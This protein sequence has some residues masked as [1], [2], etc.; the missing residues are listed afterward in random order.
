MSKVILQP[1]GGEN[2]TR[3]LQDTILNR[4]S[5]ETIGS[6]VTSEQRSALARKFPSGSA[7]VW[8]VVPGKGSNVTKWNRIE[9]HDT[10]LFTG[11]GRIFGRAEVVERFESKALAL[12]L[13]GTDE[14]GETWEYL[15]FLDSY[16][17]CDI[18]YER[19]NELVGYEPSFV[20]LGFN[21][22]TEEKSAEFL[23]AY[24]HS[25]LHPSEYIKALRAQQT[26]DREIL[27]SQRLEQQFLRQGLFGK[28]AI[29]TCCIC[30]EAYPV[31]FLVAAHVKPR[32]EC[33]PNELRD[34]KHIVAPMCRFGCDELYERGYIG[35]EGGSIVAVVSEPTSDMLEIYR[36][37]LVGRACTAWNEQSSRYFEWHLTRHRGT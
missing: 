21:V 2:A 27:A 7:L 19:F 24:N 16:E 29:G 18:P 5:L 31:G 25:N 4:V 6:H 30:G 11:H 36:E 20:P 1:A 14:D 10:A 9:A 32:S 26:L 13:W 28:D 8:G 34:F 17:E 33:E 3:H 37:D 22:L 23:T 35:V 12:E 15:Y